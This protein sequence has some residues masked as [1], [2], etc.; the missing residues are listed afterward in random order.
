MR[1]S[2]DLFVSGAAFL[3]D[4]LRILSSLDLIFHRWGF[5]RQRNSITTDPLTAKTPRRWAMR[6]WNRFLADPITR[7]RSPE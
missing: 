7:W 4:I 3:P 6:G 2:A 1:R 5:P